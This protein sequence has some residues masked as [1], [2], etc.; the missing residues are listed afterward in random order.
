L[1]IAGTYTP[2]S[3]LL[4]NGLSGVLIL[5]AVWLIAIMGI[6]LN[7]I[8]VN[9]FAKL[10][11]ASYLTMGWLIM[12]T[13]KP[14]LTNLSDFQLLMLFGGG[15]FYTVGSLIYVLGKKIKYMHSVWH[16]FVLIASVFHFVLVYST[17]G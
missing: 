7:L 3:L 17:R 15:F 13:I 5:T 1:F 2:I 12:V 10:S 16:V 4:I 14:L 8:D 9:K 6:I 11:L